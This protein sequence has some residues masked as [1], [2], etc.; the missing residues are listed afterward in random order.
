MSGNDAI[1][2]STALRASGLADT[3]ATANAVRAR[4]N[5]LDMTQRAEDAV[6]APA[7]PGAWPHDLRAALAARIARHCGHQGLADRYAERAGAGPHAALADPAEDGGRAGLA[8]VVSFV[9]AITLRPREATA[10]DIEQ[11][12]AAGIGDADIVRLAELNAFIAYQ[13]RLCAG[14]DLLGG[15]DR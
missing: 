11:L 2:S 9:D 12:K 10:S 5:V 15:S 1:W 7:E 6:L 14:L 8:P 3:G 4:A 13:A